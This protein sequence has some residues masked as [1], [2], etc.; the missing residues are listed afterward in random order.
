MG[1]AEC[2]LL[3]QSRH[4]G[5]AQCRAAMVRLS[6]AQPWLASNVSYRFHGIRTS[7]RARPLWQ[8]FKSVARLTITRPL[9]D[10]GNSAGARMFSSAANYTHPLKL[11][12]WPGTVG[13]FQYVEEIW[14]HQK[15]ASEIAV[16]FRARTLVT[17]LPGSENDSSP[18]I[19]I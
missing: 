12:K 6:A 16:P 7:V 9:F 19:G 1:I 8:P 3:G 2:E 13:L 17:H 14:A 15:I 4:C 5:F 10:R 18:A 11:L